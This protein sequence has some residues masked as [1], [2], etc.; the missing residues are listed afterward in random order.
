M[1]KR[2]RVLVLGLDCAAPQLVFDRWQDELP[3]LR[4]LMAEGISGR[5]KSCDPPI[6]V[7]AWMSMMSSKDPG[8]L[9]IYGFRNRSAYT[10][11]GLSIANSSAVHEDTVWDILGRQGKKSVLIGVP[12]TYPPKPINGHLVT[13]FLTPSVDD[14]QYTYPAE[15]KYEIERLVGRYMVDVENFRSEKKDDI[16]AQ[17]YEMTRKR[18]ALARDFVVNKTWD[19]F[20]MVEMGPDRIHHGFWKYHDVTHPKHE[21]GSKYVQAIHDYYCYLDDEIGKLLALLDDQTVVL[22]VSDHGIRKM[23][24][25]ICINEWLIRE[26]YLTLQETPKEITPFA[27]TK[28]DWARTRAWGE[29]GYYGRLYLNVKGREPEGVIHP[30]AYEE[31]RDELIARIEAIRDENGRLLGSRVMKP[32]GMY[33]S[34]GGIPPDLLVYFGDLGWRS[35]GSLGHHSVYTYENDTGPDDANHDHH[36]IFIMR[37]PSRSLAGSRDGL[38]LM[39]VA[40]TVLDRF[41]MAVPKDMQ[42]KIIT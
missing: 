28:V 22:V 17:I 2:T 25:G 37:D 24:G 34:V 29:G 7:P 4:K 12:P 5:L 18:F 6:T 10:Y 20:M 1:Q 36:G 9:G 42:G 35:V 14:N 3:N 41:G 8:Q 30:D 23:E 21:P 32:Q 15:L 31:V 19:F 40:P 39:D 13:C 26:G 11:D 16:L 38:Q 33:K 27:K